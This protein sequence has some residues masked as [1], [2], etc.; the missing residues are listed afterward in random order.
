MKKQVSEKARADT[1]LPKKET[2]LR[3]LQSNNYSDE[4][5]Q[6][7][8]RDLTSFENFLLYQKTRFEGIMK[9][10]IEDYKAYLFSINRKTAKGARAM[11]R[12]SSFS[13]NRMLSSLR[14]Y[15]KF[16]ID[17]DEF[18]PIPPEA[19]K[20]VRTEK[21]HPRVAEFVD[22]VRL[23]ESPEKLEKNKFTG[24]RNRAMLEMLFAT[25]MR[26]SEL[27]NLRKDQIDYSHGKIFIRGKGKKERFVYLTER[28]LQQLDRYMKE[29]GEDRLPHLFIP[30][31]GRNTGS[32]F[33]GIS[34]NYLQSKIK[35]YRELL[36]INVPTS[37][38]SLRHG[39]ATYLAESGANPAAIQ[40]LLGH[41]SL[42]TTTRYVHASDRYAAKEHRKFHPLKK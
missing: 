25:G 13:V 1:P 12:L 28:A 35:E 26:I 33:K 10:T 34:P 37:A 7:Y 22:L 5:L 18:V 2:F 23:I 32:M 9:S 21:K 38:H 3:F 31:R 16:M 19:I 29:R 42:D 4:T 24:W 15:L 14:N 41:E 27:V 20:L 6:N 11:Q 8:E 39:F 30:A 36:N 40:V 17:M